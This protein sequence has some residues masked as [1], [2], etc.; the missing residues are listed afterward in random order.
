MYTTIP[1]YYLYNSDVTFN[2]AEEN[3]ML[4]HNTETENWKVTHSHRIAYTLNMPQ[5]ARRNLLTEQTKKFLEDS[6]NRTGDDPYSVFYRLY[7]FAL[8]AVQ[9]SHSMCYLANHHLLE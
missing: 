9:L 3:S 5:S 8:Y 7:Y 4:V 1:D 6:Q 2:F